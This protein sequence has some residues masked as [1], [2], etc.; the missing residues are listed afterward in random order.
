MQFLE[1]KLYTCRC[2]MPYD[3]VLAFQTNKALVEIEEDS[4]SHH[5]QQLQQSTIFCHVKDGSIKIL[6]YEALGNLHSFIYA[7]RL[8]WLHE[9]HMRNSLYSLSDIDDNP[10]N[11]ELLRSDPL[12]P[13]KLRAGHS[14]PHLS[15]RY[16]DAAVGYGLFADVSIGQDVFI[17]EYVGLVQQSDR[18]R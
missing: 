15:V 10:H 5:Q 14:H 18:N 13:A 4:Q 7:P 16:V 17:G 11:A 1:P 2:I 3:R 9:K 6:S 12:V 8:V